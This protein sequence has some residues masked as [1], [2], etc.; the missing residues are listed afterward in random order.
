MR[1]QKLGSARGGRVLI[2]DLDVGM[3]QL[4]NRPRAAFT[5]SRTQVD[6]EYFVNL[7]KKQKKIKLG[8]NLNCGSRTWC[9]LCQ[10]SSSIAREVIVIIAGLQSAGQQAQHNP[11][12][13]RVSVPGP[14]E[15]DP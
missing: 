1:N 6:F 4:S 14:D 2:G 13:K 15:R 7:A 9:A 11:T 3:N 12:S 10:E 8:V 5:F